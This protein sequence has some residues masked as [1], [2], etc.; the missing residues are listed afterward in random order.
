MWILCQK[1]KRSENQTVKAFIL[2]LK[3]VVLVEIIHK[4][5]LKTLKLSEPTVNLESLY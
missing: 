3:Y 4:N 2:E 5:Y 1:M